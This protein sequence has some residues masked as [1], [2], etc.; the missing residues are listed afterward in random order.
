MLLAGVWTHTG[1]PPPSLAPCPKGCPRGVPEAPPA[2]EVSTA[3]RLPEPR[4][5]MI[6]PRCPRPLT[7]S[8]IARERPKPWQGI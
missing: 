5:Y 3:A 1:N 2:P 7:P 4:P 6:C 8:R